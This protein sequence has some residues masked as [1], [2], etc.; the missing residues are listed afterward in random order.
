[1]AMIHVQAAGVTFDNI[2]EIL[3]VIRR[4]PDR[5]TVFVAPE[6]D[7]KYD[8]NAIAVYAEGQVKTKRI[9]YLPRDLAKTLHNKEALVID[10][11]VVGDDVSGHN[12]GLNLTLDTAL[13]NVPPTKKQ[14]VFANKLALDLGKTVPDEAMENQEEMSRFIDICLKEQKTRH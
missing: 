10:F 13:E 11:M 8:E 2:Q 3:R 14:I 12:L 1:M 7:N 6:P 4:E 9:G 5:Y